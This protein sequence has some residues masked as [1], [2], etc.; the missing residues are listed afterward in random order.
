[1]PEV[2]IRKELY[3]KL[4]SHGVGTPEKVNEILHNYIA[5]KSSTSYNLS[6]DELHL[7]EYHEHGN[8]D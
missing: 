3:E 8:A 1:M 4:E 7:R 2:H 5:S 6:A